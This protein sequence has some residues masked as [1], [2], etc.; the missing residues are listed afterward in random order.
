PGTDPST[1]VAIPTTNVRKLRWTW[2]AD[3]QAGSFTRTEFQVIVSSWQVTGQ[4]AAWQVAG[5]G[6]RRIEN[7]DPTVSL[8][9]NWSLEGPGNYSG[10]SIQLTQEYGDTATFSYSEGSEHYLFLGSRLLTDGAAV[11]VSIDKQ[12]AQSF[13]L[14]LP[15]EDVL[16]RLP[17]GAVPAGA[18]TVVVA[19]NGPRS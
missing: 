16:V 11:S 13:N 18:H 10:G 7:D 17:L 4:N 19:H 15:A 6:S 8:N 5:A 3:L 9:G 14:T 12:A 1:M 2:A